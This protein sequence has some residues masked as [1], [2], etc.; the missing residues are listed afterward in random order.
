MQPSPPC[1]RKKGI[2]I[3]ISIFLAPTVD[4]PYIRGSILD[5]QA[6]IEILGVSVPCVSLCVSLSDP[7]TRQHWLP[8]VSCRCCGLLRLRCRHAPARC[9]S[10]RRQLFGLLYA[11]R[12]RPVSD[13]PHHSV[14]SVAF[15][16][17]PIQVGRWNRLACNIH[18]ISCLNA[19][20]FWRLL[21][22]LP[23][24]TPRACAAEMEEAG[25]RHSGEPIYPT[26]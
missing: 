19:G 23:A 16:R 15:F 13:C 4:E 10:T 18:A 6:A 20:S 3:S 9:I 14:W 7:R 2:L 1:V 22:A 25:D 17:A 21:L 8:D 5:P 26:K 24:T 12:R 11:H